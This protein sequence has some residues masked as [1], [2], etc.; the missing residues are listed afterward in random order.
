[1][2]DYDIH[3][4][5]CDPGF[6]GCAELYNNFHMPNEA[7]HSPT[8]NWDTILT[9]PQFM[10]EICISAG[11]TESTN[12][13]VEDQDREHTEFS[14]SFDAEYQ[15]ASK[16]AEEAP[17]GSDTKN[18]HYNNNYNGKHAEYHTATPCTDT[19]NHDN[20]SNEHQ[21]EQW[22][23]SHGQTNEVATLPDMWW[24]N[25]GLNDELYYE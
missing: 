15:E 14:I 17:T 25:L 18:L 6:D 12:F 19:L 20:S 5:E 16:Y 7:F 1:M 9:V 24:H 13:Q 21:Q 11:Y 4:Y 3:P 2:S 23:P 10:D 22:L 8:V